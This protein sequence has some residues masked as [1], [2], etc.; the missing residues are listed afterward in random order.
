MSRSSWNRALVALLA[1]VLAWL[2][3]STMVQAATETWSGG[4]ATWNSA[5]SWTGPDLPPVAGDSLVF[6]GTLNLAANNNYPGNPPTTPPT[7]FGGITR[8]DGRGVHAVGQCGAAQWEY[9]SELGQQRSYFTSAVLRQ[10]DCQHQQARRGDLVA[11]AVDF[12]KQPVLREQHDSGAVDQRQHPERQRQCLS[13]FPDRSDKCDGQQCDQ[14]RQRQDAERERR[15]LHGHGP[16]AQRHDAAT[17]NTSANLVVSGTGTLN[18]TSTTNT[19]FNIGVGAGSNTP[20]GQ[21]LATMDLT[22][23]SNFVFS[24]GTGSFGVGNLVTRSSSTLRLANTSNSITAA[25][26]VVG[27]SNHHLRNRQ[28]RRCGTL[29][30]L[31]RQ[32]VSTSSTSTRSTSA[33]PKATGCH[34]VPVRLGIGDHRRRSRRRERRPISSSGAALQQATD[35]GTTRGRSCSPGRHTANIQAGT[36]QIGVL[37]GATGGTTTGQM[38]FD[39]GTFNVSSLQL[40]VSSSGSAPE[41]QRQRC[42]PSS[43]R[44][45]SKHHGDRHTVRQCLHPVLP[46]QPDAPTPPAETLPAP[47]LINGGTANVN[48]SVDITDPSTQGGRNTSGV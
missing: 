29:D 25:N 48:T 12:R 34:S 38:T 3:G 43:W 27:D 10:L 4:G 14:Y 26:L 31:S 45:I 46:R 19:S 44:Y 32:P 15:F 18:M 11:R 30:G 47:S 9:Q 16:S 36:V 20:T 22:G 1:V 40:A 17:V 5:G 24:T 13:H 2:P 28:Q 21:P 35:T 8:A 41:C 39:T 42:A 7:L 23:L 6:D 33:L 37:A